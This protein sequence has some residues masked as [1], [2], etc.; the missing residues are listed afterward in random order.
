MSIHLARVATRSLHALVAPPATVTVYC[1]AEVS[2]AYCT[3]AALDETVQID[4]VMSHTALLNILAAIRA[5]GYRAPEQPCM[6]L[7]SDP[8]LLGEGHLDVP[9]AIALLIATQ[10]LPRDCTRGYELYGGVLPG[11]EIT[12]LRGFLP[13]L[14]AS[15][16]AG[17]RTVVVREQLPD[18][19][20]VEG[21]RIAKIANL[22]ELG[23]HLSGTQHVPLTCVRQPV[24]VPQIMP[25]VEMLPAFAL[26]AFAAAAAGGH[27]LVVSGEDVAPLVRRLATN[28]VAI[29]PLP[30]TAQATEVAIL[31][32]LSASNTALREGWSERPLRML[33][34]K[35]MPP[36]LPRPGGHPGELAQAN[37]GVLLIEEM[38]HIDGM[39][40][41]RVYEALRSG[42]AVMDSPY[43]PLEFP[44]SFQVVAGLRPCP[45]GLAENDDGCRCTYDQIHNQTQRFVSPALVDACH[46]HLKPK[47]F[48]RFTTSGKPVSPWRDPQS[49]RQQVAWVRAR[50]LGEY[51]VLNARLAWQREFRYPF[52]EAATCLWEA[53]VNKCRS[54]MQPKVAAVA[55][56][57]AYLDGEARISE[58]NLREAVLLCGAN[59]DYALD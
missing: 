20:L 52:D 19:A 38:H 10:Q 33:V 56:T 54:P 40:L 17:M 8:Q 13:M 14:I 23:E 29:L 22:R 45:C 39:S 11:G 12:G 49:V 55:L 4:A 50:S 6:V 27:S 59:M 34:A 41:G 21:A 26:R 57:L 58:R 16:A 37:H 2:N 5:S 30:T 43:T 24:L 1:L 36:L 31:S 7:V 9:I 3:I 44:T 42:R 32:S 47:Y 53:H 28:L 25:V 51:G 35:D 46:L 48:N 18:A 15:T